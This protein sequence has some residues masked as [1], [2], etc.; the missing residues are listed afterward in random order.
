[1]QPGVVGAGHASWRLKRQSSMAQCRCAPDLQLMRPHKKPCRQ[2]IVQRDCCAQSCEAAVYWTDKGAHPKHSGLSL[3]TSHHIG[4][5]F[6]TEMCTQRRCMACGTRCF[7]RMP[8]NPCRSSP[9]R[10][11]MMS[12][13]ATW[14]PSVRLALMSCARAVL[15]MQKMQSSIRYAML[16]WQNRTHQGMRLDLLVPALGLFRDSAMVVKI[17]RLCAN[18]YILGRYKS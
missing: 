11:L 13:S 10:P 2:S 15:H 1:M 18:R 3:S 7:C 9:L 14:T 8:W 12:T 5:R 16:S 4:Q 17:L 6:G